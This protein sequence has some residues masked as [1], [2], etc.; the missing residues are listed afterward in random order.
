MFK[1]FFL[2]LLLQIILL[3]PLISQVEY[4]VTI[5]GNQKN[6]YPSSLLADEEFV[7]L[8]YSM[9]Q[10][11]N[12]DYSGTAKIDEKGVIVD[13]LI[14]LPQ[15]D[16]ITHVWDI[17]KTSQAGVYSGC[18]T[19]NMQDDILYVWLFEFNSQ[20]QVLWETIIDTLHF[21]PARMEHQVVEENRYIF[22][23]DR[24]TCFYN[25]NKTTGSVIKNDSYAGTVEHLTP[26]PPEN[27]TFLINDPK[28][29]AKTIVLDSAFETVGDGVIFTERPLRHPPDCGFINNTEF[30]VTRR[31]DDN[32]NLS[33][34]MTKVEVSSMEILATKT[35]RY[36]FSMGGIGMLG[37]HTTL[38]LQKDY[39]FAFGASLLQFA[40]TPVVK[41]DNNLFLYAFNHDFD[42][43]WSIQFDFDAYYWPFSIVATPDGGCVIGATRYDW[44]TE[45]DNYFCDAFIM[46]ISKPDFTS[47]SEAEKSKPLV[48]IFPNPGNNQFLIQTELVNFTLQ[49]YDLQGQLLLTQHNRKE[50]N[51]EKLP[52]GCYIYRVIADSGEAMHGKWVKR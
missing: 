4:T 42:S 24:R 36:E 20:M 15:S 9:R 7:F 26:I 23:S 33:I 38:A 37:V 29:P 46:K 3:Q 21:V 22:C 10:G 17:K 13:S 12:E 40:P 34:I 28:D 6:G 30:V 11:Y 47:I 48:T 25:F 14:F 43:L 51:T 49:L 45:E 5:Q 1:R 19:K 50:V 27:N 18:G 31:F 16:T 2:I 39:F 32:D 8:A 41:F 35:F 44:H 52:S